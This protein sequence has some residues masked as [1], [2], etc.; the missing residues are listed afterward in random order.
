MQDPNLF[1]AALLGVIGLAST[2]A[3]FLYRRDGK[4]QEDIDKNGKAISD[5]D[6]GFVQLTT[7][8]FGHP[9]DDSDRGAVSQRA[10]EIQRAEEDIESL[11]A[12]IHSVKD[13]SEQNGT[14]IEHLEARVAQHAHSTQRALHRIETHLD[15]DIVRDDGGDLFPDGGEEDE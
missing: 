10:T 4:Q 13:Q 1:L 8:L 14:S 2:G 7:R 5:L 12:E 3:G 9:D 11:S 15:D 6:R